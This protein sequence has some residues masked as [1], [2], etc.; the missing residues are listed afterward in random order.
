MPLHLEERFRLWKN[1]AGGRG[2]LGVAAQLPPPGFGPWY[3]KWGVPRGP[4]RRR[5]RGGRSRRSAEALGVADGGVSCGPSNTSPVG[6]R[7][8]EQKLRDIHE[9]CRGLSTQT[10]GSAW[11][12]G[13]A[14]RGVPG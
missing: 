10:G 11:G 9:T 1:E 12:G 6:R 14:E 13:D 2:V 4:A 7:Q 3:R 5:W 8:C